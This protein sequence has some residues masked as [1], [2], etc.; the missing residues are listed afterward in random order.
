[1]RL[2][3]S[4]LMLHTKKCKVRTYITREYEIFS[5]RT[6]VKYENMICPKLCYTRKYDV[7][8]HNLRYIR[9][10]VM[11]ISVYRFKIWTS[12]DDKLQSL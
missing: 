11:S 3:L 10:C 2:F 7:W 12:D 6:Y 5:V 4:E 9:K 8:S 1:M